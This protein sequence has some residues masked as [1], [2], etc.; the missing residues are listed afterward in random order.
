[1]HATA[2]THPPPSSRKP[3]EPGDMT[4]LD[5]KV[6]DEQTFL[7]PL[8]RHDVVSSSHLRGKC[9]KGSV[10][11]RT[12]ANPAFSFLQLILSL[13]L[14]T[15]QL[16]TAH[17]YSEENIKVKDDRGPI[18]YYSEGVSLHSNILDILFIGR[19]RVAAMCRKIHPQLPF[20]LN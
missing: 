3:R 9:C 10:P 14:V 12:R 2:P 5:S 6:S 16:L 15:Q 7:R 17:S 4:M 19:M 11:L 1:M 8:V 20:T 18:T 13:A